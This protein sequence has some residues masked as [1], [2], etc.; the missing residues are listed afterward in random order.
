MDLADP[1]ASV[2]FSI[3][4]IEGVRENGGFRHS[5]MDTTFSTFACVVIMAKDGS[6]QLSSNT[7]TSNYSAQNYPLLLPS[8]G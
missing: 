4:S 8:D 2:L 5:R 1:Q 7:V 3:H 6:Q